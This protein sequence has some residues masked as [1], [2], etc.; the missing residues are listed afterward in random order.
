MNEHAT[1]ETDRLRLR[2]ITEQDSGAIWVIHSD[3]RT[4]AH[5]PAGPM[6]Q[7]PDADARA[8]EWAAAWADDGQGYW[9]VED[10]QTP[11]T[12]IGFGGIRLV[13]WRGRPVYNL[14]YRFA[15]AAWGRGLA[16]EL[17]AAA[18]ARWHALG[19]RHPLVAYTTADNLASQR[20]AA[21]GGLTRRPDLDEVT[22]AYT[23][24]VFALGLD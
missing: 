16:S 11:G 2:P 12:V 15:P 3:P 24:V 19:E 1:L 13:E 14:Y 4:N 20:T 9:A 8:R 6:T 22:G 10:R 5:N 7:R 18:V 23:D 17:V 21:R